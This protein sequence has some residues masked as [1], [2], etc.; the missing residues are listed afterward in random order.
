MSSLQY[1]FFWN[2]KDHTDN[3]WH[4]DPIHSNI[5]RLNNL[6]TQLKRLDIDATCVD[7]APFIFSAGALAYIRQL[8]LFPL[9]AHA[10]PFRN[11]RTLAAWHRATLVVAPVVLACQGLGLD[12]RMLI[13]RWCSDWERRR[14][15]EEVRGHVAFGMYAG[16]ASW[17]IRM[18]GLRRGRA[19]WAPIDVIMGGALTD[20]AHREYYKTH[21]F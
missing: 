1:L 2:F 15:E 16:A 7:A 17:F 12:Y 6:P 19:Y 8:H 14:E 9:E 18:Y 20:L 3:Q 10:S 21:N 4:P 13:P 11:L 5:K